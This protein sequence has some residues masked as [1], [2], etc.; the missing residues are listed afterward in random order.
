M[1]WRTVRGLVVMLPLLASP[2]PGLD[3]GQLLERWGFPMA[4]VAMLVLGWL[5]PGPSHKAAVADKAASEQRE[6]ETLKLLAD[7]VIP[8]LTTANAT[9]GRTADAL[10]RNT[11]ALERNA[12]MLASLRPILERRTRGGT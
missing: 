4:V 10:E 3:V 6:R 8:A 1:I 9:L 2:A 5:V 12:E 11:G 7:Q